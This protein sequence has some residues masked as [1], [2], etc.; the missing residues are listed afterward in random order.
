M[1]GSDLNFLLDEIKDGGGWGLRFT[2]DGNNLRI[3]NVVDI[4]AFYP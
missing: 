1:G 2:N 3:T 4:F